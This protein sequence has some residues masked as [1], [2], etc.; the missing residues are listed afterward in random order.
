MKTR[1]NRIWFAALYLT[2]SLGTVEAQSSITVSAI[3]GPLE[4]ALINGGTFLLGQTAV[5][6]TASILL[7]VRNLSSAPVDITRYVALG[8]GF[9]LVARNV[10]F[11]I[12]GNASYDAIL[13]F[14]PT[15]AA[16][17]SA[18]LQI[19]TFATQLLASGIGPPDL[20]ILP[21]C[22]TSDP[23]TIL[24]G[25]VQKGQTRTCNFTLRNPGTTPM[26]IP[27]FFITGSEFINPQPLA[28]PFTLAVGQ[29]ISFS[30]Q[31]KTATVGVK[32]ATLSIQSQTFTLTAT[33]FDA[34]LPTPVL[35]FSGTL[36]G[37]PATIASGQ[38]VYV[39]MRL[40][41]PAPFTSTGVLTMTLIPDS[42]L[43]TDDRAVVFLGTGLTSVPFSVQQGSTA[44]LLSGQ[45]ALGF[46]T[47]TT[48]G[49]IRFTL[50]QIASGFVSDPTVD[51]VIPRAPVELDLT[52]TGRTSGFLFVK[53][54]GF[55]NTY[56]TGP[57]SF[58]FYNAS[59]SLL[60]T[61]PAD[62]SKEF[63]AYYQ[64]TLTG[65]L[66]NASLQFNVNNAADAVASVEVTLTNSAGTTHS[67]RIPF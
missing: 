32:S 54:T 15:A 35:D 50:S 25:N 36:T 11:T 7:R 30:I 27:A 6:D 53:L 60:Q 3:T 5:G 41:S 67:G 4:T 34:P 42:S 8:A 13:Y 44:V 10:P 23:H 52:Q 12:A 33:S 26:N 39:A 49:R 1:A 31:F 51:L 46:Q 24:F 14:T 66:F 2:L 37:G 28:T 29:T 22:N 48:S 40:P 57:L 56:S 17:Y 20:T 58:A 9:T 21:T 59:G 63:Q 47:G 65:S 45:I 18:N 16:S 19:N 62:F 38:Q 61:V 55:D 43:V 64:G